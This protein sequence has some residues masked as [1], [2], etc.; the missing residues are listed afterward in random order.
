MHISPCTYGN[1]LLSRASLVRLTTCHPS[2][3]L[4]NLLR[5]ASSPEAFPGLTHRREATSGYST[6]TENMNAI[7]NTLAE[8]IGGK[9]Q[10]IG[11]HQFSLDQVPDLTGKVAVVTGGSEG[12]GFGCTHTLLKHNIGKVY[13]LSVS[14]EEGAKDA[15]AK[16]LGQ[17]A[18][19]KTRWIRCDLSDWWKVKDVAEEISKESD[20]LDIL[21]NNAGRG[22]MTYQLTDYGV[23]RHMAVNHMGHAILTSHLLPLMKQTA[24][25][26]NIVRIT[27][28]AS[29]AHQAAPSDTKFESL[30]ELNRDLGANAQYGR[31]KLANIL[32]ARY[33]TEKVT[34]AGYPKLLMNATH[35]GFVSTK[36]SKE[37]IFEP[38]P[39]GG[40]AM[41]VGMEPFKKDQFEGAVSAMFASTYT[42]KSGQYICPPA[43]PESGSKL[44]Q[45]KVL[46]DNLMKL[47]WK[48]VTEKTNDGVGSCLLLN[49]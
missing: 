17:Q 13:I 15:I 27:N 14:E 10:N 49:N 6:L 33:F 36:M 20:R 42:E 8:N 32:Y 2:F 21:I 30:E 7:K 9:F 4:K 37:D 18:A 28:Q 45:D 40:Y 39:L 5:I 46:A 23:D 41:A 34:K 31:S 19:D 25:K 11:T 47:T 43:V 1:I 38:F 24:E 29:N 3:Y 35:P 48:I 16:Q 44:S 12:I 26:G 22:I